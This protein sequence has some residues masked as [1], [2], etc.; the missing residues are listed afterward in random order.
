MT[1]DAG[2]LIPRFRRPAQWRRYGALSR[3][4]KTWSHA[5][6]TDRCRCRERGRGQAIVLVAGSRR[7]SCSHAGRAASSQYRSASA[8]HARYFHRLLVLAQ[9]G[10]RSR[11]PQ[12]G[13]S[14]PRFS[15][16]RA[17]LEQIT[18][19]A[20][21]TRSAIGSVRATFS[22][23]RRE[24]QVLTNSFPSDS[25]M[26]PAGVNSVTKAAPTRWRAIC[27]SFCRHA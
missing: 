18:S 13:A 5:R 12:Q 20:S 7:C 22:R 2:F 1:G 15:C 11:T 16:R 24:F 27:S 9:R 10:D 3:R 4:S 19:M 17:P 25:V 8:D 6:H 26:R 14:G 21:Q 23:G